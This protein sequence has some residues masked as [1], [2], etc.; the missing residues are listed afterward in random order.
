M[1]RLSRWPRPHIE[2]SWFWDGL[3][4]GIRDLAARAPS[5]AGADRSCRR[6]PAPGQVSLRTRL[7]LARKV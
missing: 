7:Q 6:L 5:D 2:A 4:C 3:T 1:V